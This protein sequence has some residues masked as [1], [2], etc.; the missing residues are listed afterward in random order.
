MLLSNKKQGIFFTV[1]SNYVNK[2]IIPFMPYNVAMPANPIAKKQASN[3]IV[4]TAYF[5][6]LSRLR[7]RMLFRAS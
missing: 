2:N 4:K 7:S 5:S 1:I 6:I 3:F